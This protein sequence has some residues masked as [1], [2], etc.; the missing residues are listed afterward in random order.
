MLEKTSSYWN[1]KIPQLE[2]DIQSTPQRIP[3]D[4]FPSSFQMVHQMLMS[5]VNTH[6]PELAEEP[7]KKRR[8]LC[9]SIHELVMSFSSDCEAE[10]GLVEHFDH[11]RQHRRKRRKGD[12]VKA[13][14]NV[15]NRIRQFSY[16]SSE[17]ADDDAFVID[18]KAIAEEMNLFEEE[19]R[20][21]GEEELDEQ[22]LVVMPLADIDDLLEKIFT[23]VEVAKGKL[24]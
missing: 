8:K 10:V 2:T 13:H 5:S 14:R 6:R 3:I 23:A 16:S 11:R 4:P 7:F 21:L 19:E 12:R 1:P 24:P 17:P 20:E 18:E 22:Q 9:H 15:F